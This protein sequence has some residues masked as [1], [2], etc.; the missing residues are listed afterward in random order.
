MRIESL[1]NHKDTKTQRGDQGSDPRRQ[2]DERLATSSM[3]RQGSDPSSPLCVFVSL[4]LLTCLF[5]LPSYAADKWLSVRSKNFLVIG[6]ANEPDIRR[7]GRS[8]EEFRSAF[9]MMFPKVDQTST[10][11]TTIIVFKN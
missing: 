2:R 4:W 10:V 5:A 8:L 9:A 6:N 7:V 11:P 1:S 3:S